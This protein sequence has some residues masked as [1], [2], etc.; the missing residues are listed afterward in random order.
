MRFLGGGGVGHLGGGAEM[1]FQ[2][3]TNSPWSKAG[4]NDAEGP[5]QEVD[6]EARSETPEE[7]SGS[8][9]RSDS[10]A[11]SEPSDNS[12]DSDTSDTSD[13]APGSDGDD[14]FYKY[15]LE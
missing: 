11:E 7:P 6:T 13:Y 4:E 9:G 2:G 8:D 14:D 3:S 12:C 10:E 1:V 15:G 5:V